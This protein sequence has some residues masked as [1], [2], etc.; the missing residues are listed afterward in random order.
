MSNR[1]EVGKKEHNSEKIHFGALW[2]KYWVL[3]AVSGID[4]GVPFE[5]VADNKKQH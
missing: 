2:W 1:T 5:K 3:L 4:V